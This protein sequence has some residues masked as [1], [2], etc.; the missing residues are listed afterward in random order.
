M[1]NMKKAIAALAAGVMA[2]PYHRGVRWRQWQQ[3]R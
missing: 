3:H 1:K 2:R